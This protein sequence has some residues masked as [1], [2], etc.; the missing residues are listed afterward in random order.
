MG[1]QLDALRPT[2][3]ARVLDLVEAAGIDVSD[4]SNFAGGAQKAAS[5]PKYCYEWAFVQPDRAVVVNLWHRQMHEES[6]KVA[7]IMRLKNRDEFKGVR[8][9]RLERLQDALLHA[10][11]KGVPL[12][13]IIN[14]G[15]MTDSDQDDVQSAH[16]TARLLDLMPWHVASYDDSTGTWKL[17]R[18]PGAHGSVDQFDTRTVPQEVQQ[19]TTVA[20]AFVRSPEVRRVALRRAAGRCEY[21]GALGFV[22]LDGMVFLETHHVVPLSEGGP[23]VVDNVAALCPNHH[24]EAHFGANGCAMRRQLIAQLRM[25]VSAG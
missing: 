13:V 7:V 6:S 4:W 25:N 9:N 10:R 23:D 11:A 21:C 15:T 2:E 24:R 1:S 12:R 20:K 14:A 18:G 16:V 22:M 17:C 19:R 8:K 3:R 5:N